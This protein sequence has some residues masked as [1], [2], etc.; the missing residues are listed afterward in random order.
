MFFGLRRFVIHDLD[1]AYAQSMPAL[2]ECAMV[3]AQLQ[4][5]KTCKHTP[6]RGRQS[7][8]RAS[9][10]QERCTFSVETSCCITVPALSNLPIDCLAVGRKPVY[11]ESQL[12]DRAKFVV[13]VWLFS[14]SL[15]QDASLAAQS[16]VPYF[17]IKET[18]VF[19]SN[20]IL[21]RSREDIS[22]SPI[23]PE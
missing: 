19:T 17:G 13:V 14:F 7:I 11:R 22:S 12:S 4:A 10:M 5:R 9:I 20:Y 21:I 15:A 3:Y 6:Y 16:P 2:M 18:L 1:M 23:P 8:R